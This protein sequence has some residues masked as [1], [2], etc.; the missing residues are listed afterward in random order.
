M[1]S[2]SKF[3]SEHQRK[4]RQILIDSFLQIMGIESVTPH[5]ADLNESVNKFF[6]E[7]LVTGGAE[8]NFNS[9]V[10]RFAMALIQTLI[11]QPFAA[12]ERCAKVKESLEE[13]ISLSVYQKKRRKPPSFSYG[14][15]SRNKVNA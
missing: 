8:C 4:L 13:L 6:D 3:T 7:M 12:E 5:R 14:D 15:I 2:A 1:T 10:E 11:T 9:P